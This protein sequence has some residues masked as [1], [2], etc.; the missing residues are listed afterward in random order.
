VLTDEQ[1]R[2][3]TLS[4]AQSNWTPRSRAGRFVSATATDEESSHIVPESEEGNSL[5]GRGG[6][7]GSIRKNGSPI[8]YSVDVY[9]ERSPNGAA[10]GIPVFV[11][12]WK[13]VVAT[14]YHGLQEAR[15]D[16]DVGD[17]IRSSPD[18]RSQRRLGWISN[19]GEE[20]GDYPISASRQLTDVVREVPL[21]DGS[22]TVPVQ[23]QYSNAVH[24]PEGPIS[25]P[26]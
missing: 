22:G 6:F 24:G 16:P 19:R 2:S 8:Y 4:T 10:N 5:I 26:H 17:V 9:S 21:T 7:H 15:T 23:F 20:V 11:Q 12:P 14:L 1:F 25:Q 3:G 18:P 13:N